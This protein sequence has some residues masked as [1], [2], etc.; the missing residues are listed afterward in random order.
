MHFKGTI[1]N[2]ALPSMYG[3]SIEITLQSL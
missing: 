1:V 3:G 2:R